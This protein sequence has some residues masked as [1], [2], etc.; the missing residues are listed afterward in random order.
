MVYL[1][2]LYYNL[3]YIF[4]SF[5]IIRKLLNL[6]NIKLFLSFALL[7]KFMILLKINIIL[8]IYYSKNLF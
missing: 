7:Y 6:F 5:K 1:Y 2:I 3:S 4:K 8:Y